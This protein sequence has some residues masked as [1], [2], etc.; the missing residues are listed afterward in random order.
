VS[1]K[2]LVQY[3][4]D[5]VSALREAS[6]AAAMG[7]ADADAIALI[8]LIASGA[9]MTEDLAEGRLRYRLT[10]PHVGL[11]VWTDDPQQ[12]GALD[13]V[14]A[15]VHSASAGRSVLVARA[16]ATSRWIW[17]SGTE[18]PDL[19]HVEKVAKAQDVRVAVGRPGTDSK[20]SGQATKTPWRPRRWSFG[21]DP[22]GALRRT[23]T[24]S[25]STASRR[26]A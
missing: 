19:H 10:R 9:P 12:A 3:A 25:S 18:T 5:S 11:V 24:S 13:E 17:L 20:G 23:P 22:T 26:T 8:Q 16:S 14:V 7:N 15:A 4:L 21:S 6:L 2:S 1:A